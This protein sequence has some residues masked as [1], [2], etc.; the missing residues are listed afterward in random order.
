MAE[1]NTSDQKVCAK[2]GSELRP[3]NRFCVSC[4]ALHGSSALEVYNKKVT[5][6]Q[7]TDYGRII[8]SLIGGS[9]KWLKDMGEKQ[10]VLTAIASI[11]GIIILWNIAGSL[12]Y[13][14]LIGGLL[15]ALGLTAMT[16][17]F[18]ALFFSVVELHRRRVRLNEERRRQEE[19]QRQRAEEE[20][21]RRVEELRQQQL[22]Y[23]RWFESLS[24][25]E[26]QVELTKQMM[27][28]QEQQM[29]QMMDQ[30]NRNHQ[31]QQSADNWRTAALLMGIMNNNHR[32]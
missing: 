18:F 28:R 20:A 3:G 32:R 2:C 21:I 8:G 13:L 6:G 24:P 4:G 31:E 7:F 27:I 14:P 29:Q 11:T 10:P 17:F 1:S 12:A 26:Q 23:R 22:A 5:E 19:L 30:Q 25:A 9:V 15:Y 16:P